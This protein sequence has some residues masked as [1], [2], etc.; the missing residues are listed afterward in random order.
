MKTWKDL[1]SVNTPDRVA[2]L[3]KDERGY[4]IPHTVQWA[5]GK[6]DF[7]VI[8]QVKWIDAVSSCKCGI[9]GEKIEG[10]MAFTGGP[11]SIQNRLFTDL[12]MHKECAE[13]ALQVC[14]FLAMPKFGYL[15][16]AGYKMPVKVM[17]AVSNDRPDKFGLGM[18]DGFRVARIGHAGEDIAIW[19]NEFTSVEWWIN[20][21][22]Q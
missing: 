21:E 12:P 6:P 1:N 5:N 10:Q 15:D 20:G 14:P 4:P 16:K 17:S 22:R 9:C 7:R 2:A 8:D 19:A 3:Q 18:T 11:L 13:Y